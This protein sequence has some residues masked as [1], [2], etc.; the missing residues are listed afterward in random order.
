MAAITKELLEAAKANL[1]LQR[2]N[3]VGALNKIEGALEV[4]E[5]QLVEIDKPEPKK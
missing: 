4:V 1:L 5:G 3:V 2:V